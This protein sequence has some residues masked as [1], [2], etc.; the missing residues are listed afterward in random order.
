M[1][2]SPQPKR[3]AAYYS[4]KKSSVSHSWRRSLC[5]LVG[6]CHQ[7]TAMRLGLVQEYGNSSPLKLSHITTNI[8]DYPLFSLKTVSKSAFQEPGRKP[9]LVVDQ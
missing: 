4:D 1:S 8:G 7:T 2:E 3:I 9:H 5:S 6:G